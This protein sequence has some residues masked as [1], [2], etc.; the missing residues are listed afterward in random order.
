MSNLEALIDKITQDCNTKAQSIL[1]AANA[2]AQKLIQEKVD[3]ANAK[4]E[5]ILN[6]A[7]TEAAREK[8]QIIAG[9]K[10]S[11]RDKKLKAKQ[12]VIDQAFAMAVAKLKELP[13]AEYAKFLEGY[14]LYLG[15]S[16]DET[17]ILPKRYG[18]VN[19]AAIND[20]LKAKGLKGE[21]TVDK[22]GRDIEGGFILTKGGIENNNT[23]EALLD[24]YREELEVL[25]VENL[26]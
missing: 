19:I 21:L 8:E 6:A 22:D 16:G 12:D 2:N 7:Q 14:L 18:S 5:Q 17:L 9:Q 24:Y 23:Y 1:D 11:I 26:F 4:K 13:E 20:K 25:V 3:A 10:L 15:I